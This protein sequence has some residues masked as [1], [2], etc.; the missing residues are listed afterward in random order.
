MRSRHWS[1][2]SD[3]CRSV[4]MKWAGPIRK[5]LGVATRRA[6]ISRWGNGKESVSES[7]NGMLPCS[8]GLVLQAL[9]SG[10]L[11]ERDAQA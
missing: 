2:R 1:G 3:H 6:I 4:F 5:V 9:L 7:G 11:F 8:F 10:L